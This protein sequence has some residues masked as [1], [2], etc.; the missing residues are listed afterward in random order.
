MATTHVEWIDR[1]GTPTSALEARITAFEASEGIDLHWVARHHLVGGSSHHD[2]PFPRVEEHS[3]YLFGILYSPSDPD[4]VFAEFDELVFVATHDRVFGTYSRS[5]RSRTSWPDIFESM[6]TDTVFKDAAAGGGRIIV[7]M[8]KAIV[9]Q[10]VRDAE[11]FDKSVASFAHDLGINPD[12]SD[13]DSAAD[14]VRAMSRAERRDI[15]RMIIDIGDR[16]AIHRREVPLMRRV[17]DETEAILEHL[18]HDRLDLTTD[19]SGVPR[20]LFNRELEIFISDTYVDA[21]HVSSLADDIDYRLGALRDYLRQVKD[22][23]NV[24]A[25]RFTGAIASIM[26]VPTFI[27]GLYGQNFVNFPELGWEYGYHIS[28]A[29][30]VTVTIGQVWFFKRRRWI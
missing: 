18:S 29:A 28:W 23:E 3:G 8:L 1:G 25:N 19:V 6:T 21:R 14:E 4:D 20:Q 10:L 26:L 24:A 16:I 15:R 7:R 2:D 17:V 9:K 12:R 5:P 13:F 27:V 22:D 11:N 30:I